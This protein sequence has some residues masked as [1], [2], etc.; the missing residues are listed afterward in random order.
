M[1]ASWV[2][3]VST[4]VPRYPD[5]PTLKR[6]IRPISANPC[7]SPEFFFDLLDQ[8]STFHCQLSH[9]HT[10]RLHN[11]PIMAAT[12]NIQKPYVL[13]SLPRPL[14][15]QGDSSYQVGDVWGQQQ[16]SK[17]RKRSELAVG[18]DGE[19]LNLYDVS[20]GTQPPMGI[21]L[22]TIHRCRLQD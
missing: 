17:K 4:R 19:A 6:L 7:T 15:Q 20:L 16:G 5:I 2:P 3:W 11:L 22:L 21:N 8:T 10:R 18:I 14:N 1:V 12:F 9:S 13:T